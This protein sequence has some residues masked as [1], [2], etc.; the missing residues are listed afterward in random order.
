MQPT[1]QLTLKLFH[2]HDIP[3]VLQSLSKHQNLTIITSCSQVH[4]G[5][6]PAKMGTYFLTG[7]AVMSFIYFTSTIF[8]WN[9]TPI[10][11]AL[12]QPIQVSQLAGDFA[13]IYTILGVPFIYVYELIR[14]VSPARNEAVSMLVS[15]VAAIFLNVGFGYHLACWTDW[16]W[17]GASVA[18]SIGNVVL[19]PTS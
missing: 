1:V 19:A 6:Q 12:G 9:T 3:S 7:G 4:G 17:T 15:A 14:K 16:G 10:L 13:I 11:I 2:F 5:S 18:Y 8:I